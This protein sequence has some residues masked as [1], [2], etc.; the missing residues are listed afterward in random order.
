MPTHAHGK[1]RRFLLGSVTAKVL[2]DVECQILAGVHH[3]TVPLSTDG[4]IRQIICAVD[5]TLGQLKLEAEVD[6]TISLAG[7]A[8]STVIREAALRTGADLVVIGRSHTQRELGR[9]RT[10]TYSI[11]RHS[12]CPV[13]SI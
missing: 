5:E 12:P 11:I 3:E 6:V 1:Y 4:D 9:L 8:V 2:H 7:G 13:P 10:Q